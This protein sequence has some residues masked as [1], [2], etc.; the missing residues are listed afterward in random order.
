MGTIGHGR[1]NTGEIEE[2][3][4]KTKSEILVDIRLQWEHIRLMREGLNM[5]DEGVERWNLQLLLYH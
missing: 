5:Q 4:K 1:R 3:S 2:E